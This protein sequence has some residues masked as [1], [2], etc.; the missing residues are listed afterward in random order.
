MI[1][2]LGSGK[3]YLLIVGIGLATCSR[4]SASGSLAPEPALS[5]KAEPLQ[6]RLQL[7][8]AF[9]IPL[10]KSRSLHSVSLACI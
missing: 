6:R 5:E 10:A 9:C 3:L 2:R 4:A 1:G 7:V 8:L